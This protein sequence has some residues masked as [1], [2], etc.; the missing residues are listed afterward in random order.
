MLTIKGRVKKNQKLLMEIGMLT[1]GQTE[2]MT[3]MFEDMSL[4]WIFLE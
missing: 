2:V 1:L 3:E 4:F